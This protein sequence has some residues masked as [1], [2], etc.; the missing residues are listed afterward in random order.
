MS[1]LKSIE[2]AGYV[3]FWRPPPV[4]WVARVEWAKLTFSLTDDVSL[5]FRLTTRFF[6][7]AIWTRCKP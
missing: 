1:D 5:W 3:S 4:R 7:G 6:F 2:G